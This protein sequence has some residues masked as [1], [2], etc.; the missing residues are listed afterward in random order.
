[1]KQ[2]KKSP[3]KPEK[4]TRRQ[5]NSL[6]LYFSNLAEELNDS[7]YD[8][9]KVLR[10]D[11]PWSPMTVKEYLWRPLQEAYL[12]KRSTT[13]LN[14]EKEI[15]EVYEILNRVIAERC[16]IHCPFPSIENIDYMKDSPLKPRKSE[17]GVKIAV[18]E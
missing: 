14:K 8:M 6:H 1:M 9:K 2:E 18:A 10:V 5:Q 7:G 17:D 16:G 3:I 4:L 11:I 15:S 13:E 12:L